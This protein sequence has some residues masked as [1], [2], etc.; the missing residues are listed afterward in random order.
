MSAVVQHKSGVTSSSP[1]AVAFNSPVTKGNLIVAVIK[2]APFASAPTDNAGNT[3]TQAVTIGNQM[4]IY[5]ATAN[6]TGN[7]TVTDPSVGETMHMHIYEVTGF[8]ALDQ[9][10]SFAG[11]VGGSAASISTSGPTTTATELVVALFQSTNAGSFSWTPQAG[12]DAS[13][14]TTD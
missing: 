13:E 2:G 4:V 3:Y 7:L 10:G 14:S 12:V 5:V 11:S 9:S 8:A 1:L 6:A